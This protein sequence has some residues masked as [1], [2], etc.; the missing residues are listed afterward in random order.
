VILLYNILLC[1]QVMLKIYKAGRQHIDKAYAG[2]VE[3]LSLIYSHR[4]ALWR[5]PNYIREI[6]ASLLF[7]DFLSK[8]RGDVAFQLVPVIADWILSNTD[9]AGTACGFWLLL[10]IAE[11]S[12]TT[13][14]PVG[15]KNRI[16]SLGQK[17][18]VNGEAANEPFSKLLRYYRLHSPIT[19]Q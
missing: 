18:L 7:I 11:S 3:S 2:D 12:S 1:P 9:P 14:I 6:P 13:E 19:A 15:L 17:A 16:E 5:D 8:M 10:S 4:A